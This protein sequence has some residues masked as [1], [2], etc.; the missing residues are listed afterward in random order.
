M[1]GYINRHQSLE[2]LSNTCGA[3]LIVLAE[4]RKRRLKKLQDHF[5]RNEKSLSAVKR[6]EI[7]RKINIVSLQCRAIEEV[8]R[9][10]E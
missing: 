10:G 1:Y 9:T 5:T 6:M 3:Y 2:R 7:Q 4:Q 8:L